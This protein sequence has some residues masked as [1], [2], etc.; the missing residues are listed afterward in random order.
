MWISLHLPD[1]GPIIAPD[2]F[3]YLGNATFIVRGYGHPVNGYFGGYSLLLVP[4]A[5]LRSAPHSFYEAALITNALLSLVTA[6]LAFLLARRLFPNIHA[7]AAS[8]VA[9]SVVLQPYVFSVAHLAMSENALVPATLL[10]ALL[11]AKYA[12]Q[13]SHPV[14]VAAGLAASLAFW[15]SPR[16]ILVVAAFLL[17][18]LVAWIRSRE[19]L[20][21]LVVITT[22]VVASAALSS[23]FNRA[24]RG[25]APV[26]G[27][28]SAQTFPPL[29]RAA[30]W[31]DFIAGT[32]G[33]FA[34][35]GVATMGLAFVGLWVGAVWLFERRGS[36]ESN[37]LSP[38]AIVGVFAAGSVVLT[39]AFSTIVTK[40]SRI[41]E[42][43]YGRYVEGVA[44]PMVVIGAGWLIAQSR[45]RMRKLSL[46]RIAL[47]T[48]GAVGMFVVLARLFPKPPPVSNEASVNVVAVFAIRKVAHL[49]G[50]NAPL[51]FVG[52]LAGAIL[53][54]GIIDSKL[55]LI[56]VA[57]VFTIGA[58]SI[59]Y[60]FR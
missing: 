25:R 16:G 35:L 50:Y 41:D 19:R 54:L 8:L 7:F 4:A 1:K 49:H 5:V 46:L 10:A 56:A 31:R 22:T 45:W 13:R 14:G 52:L 30:T 53:L 17:A 58:S 27:V 34:Y 23:V 24:L 44:M 18:Y 60:Q 42:L 6:A 39:I 15:I 9:A 21:E 3:G 12:D 11:L 47:C 28:E 20:G 59:Y 37:G 55:S 32:S 29:T 2:E 38:R 43:Y 48:T 40:V 36:V 33:R 26:P 57:V 51:L